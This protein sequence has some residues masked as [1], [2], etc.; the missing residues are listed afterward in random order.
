M[1]QFRLQINKVYVGKKPGEGFL[2]DIVQN[3]VWA[4]QAI[5]G[6]TLTA[7]NR[8]ANKHCVVEIKPT[9]L[10][11]SDCLL[12]TLPWLYPALF[13]GTEKGAS[14]ASRPLQRR[15]EAAIARKYITRLQTL[16]GYHQVQIIFDCTFNEVKIEL[17][18]TWLK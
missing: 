17:H 10:T 2:I 13:I 11:T 3:L 14:L 12:L 8:L 16:E 5:Q 18:S 15:V 6:R 9:N 4:A 1:L 7:E